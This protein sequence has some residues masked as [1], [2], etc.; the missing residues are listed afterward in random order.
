M[1]MVFHGDTLFNLVR[2]IAPDV[3]RLFG[4]VYDAIGTSEEEMVMRQVYQQLKPLNFSKDV[5]EPYVEA[6]PSMV[7]GM[8]IRDVLWSDW[9]TESRI[10]E[11]LRRTGCA[12]RLNGL[13]VALRQS[14][15]LNT[16]GESTMTESQA[17]L[18]CGTRPSSTPPTRTLI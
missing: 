9:G 17:G 13:S 3:Y 16:P 12:A 11:V 14:Q 8:T 10:M 15:N 5:L 6:H 2:E 18:A 7:L 1:M 4:C